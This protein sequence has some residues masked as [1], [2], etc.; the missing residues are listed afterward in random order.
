MVVSGVESAK[1]KFEE[2]GQKSMSTSEKMGRQWQSFKQNWF[3]ITAG[4]AAAAAAIHGVMKAGLESDRVWNDVRAS[5]ERHNQALGGGIERIQAW[6]SQMQE[7]T[8]LSDEAIGT[9]FQRMIDANIKF[10]DALKLT[11][12]AMDF[13]VAKGMD[14]ESSAELIAKSIDGPVNALSRYGIAIDKS[15]PRMRQIAQVQSEINQHFGGAAADRMHSVAGQVDLLGQRWDELQETLFKLFSPTLAEAVSGLN[16]DLKIFLTL[17]EKLKNPLGRLRVDPKTL[18]SFNEL[19]AALSRGAISVAEYN[20]AVRELEKPKELFDVESLRTEF[21]AVQAELD[22]QKRE[23]QKGFQESLQWR[24]EEAFGGPDVL[25]H[26]FGLG[27]GFG[28]EVQAELQA[29]MDAELQMQSEQYAKAEA[30]AAEFRAKQLEAERALNAQKFEV[31]ADAFG[32]MSELL[33]AFSDREGAMFELGKGFAAARAAISAYAG[34][35]KAIEI[36]GPTPWGFVAAASAIAYGLAQVRNI[37]A[38]QPRQTA[39]PVA[40][41][42]AP[43]QTGNW[44]GAQSSGPAVIT[45]N[46]AGT[47]FGGN[48]DAVARELVGALRKAELDYAR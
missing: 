1:R 21:L 40:S 22:R 2:L 6:A 24:P 43:A 37:L 34:A 8:G 39:M 28:A 32:A 9:A 44:G 17:L 15:L 14:L 29:Q 47:V 20:R 4:I 5:I 27:A 38:Q 45:I 11:Q 35:A 13:S 41:S 46:F 3:A 12:S 19:D 36:Y 23:I 25:A 33:L 48:R 18:T 30:M 42:A 31:A 7:A 16:D 10:N 26:T